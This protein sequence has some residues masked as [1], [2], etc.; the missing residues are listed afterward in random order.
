MKNVFCY[1]A[2]VISVIIIV[3]AF[4]NLY[5]ESPGGELLERYGWEF[6]PKPVETSELVIPLEFDE[7]F[8]GYNEL[9]KKAGLDL[10]PYRGKRATRYT[11]II[12][13][14]PDK[15]LNVRGNVLVADNRAIGGDICTVELNGFMEALNFNLTNS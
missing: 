13:N 8:A 9:Q 6:E 2:A 14:Y 4:M 12:T 7:V 1:L 3:F 15:S 5:C 11:Y 10:E